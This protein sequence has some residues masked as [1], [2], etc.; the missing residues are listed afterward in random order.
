MS[1]YSQYIG[2]A[3]KT[4]KRFKHVMAITHLEV[5][6]TFHKRFRGKDNYFC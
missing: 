5:P 2:K 6:G 4:D 3:V 1:F